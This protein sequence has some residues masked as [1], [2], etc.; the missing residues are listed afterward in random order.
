MIAVFCPEIEMGFCPDISCGL[1]DNDIYT[2][3]SYLIRPILWV[4]RYFQLF[5]IALLVVAGEFFTLLIDKLNNIKKIGFEHKGYLILIL[6]VYPF[7]GAMNVDYTFGKWGYPSDMEM[8]D[9]MKTLPSDS[10]VVAPLA[11]TVPGSRIVRIEC[12]GR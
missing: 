9:Y 1:A 5:D 10:L 2:Y 7:Y 4:D 8:L 3:G 6:L 11:C 12:A